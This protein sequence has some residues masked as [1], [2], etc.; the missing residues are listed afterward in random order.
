M[1]RRSGYYNASNKIYLILLT[2]VQGL[3]Y[4]LM[5]VLLKS[6]KKLTKEILTKL[7]LIFYLYLFTGIIL[8]LLTYFLSDMITSIMFGK[9]FAES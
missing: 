5:P 6:V 4:T 3:S 2:V 8:S 1:S 9:Q 7:S